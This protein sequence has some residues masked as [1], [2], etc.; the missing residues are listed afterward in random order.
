[1]IRII[2]FHFHA[3]FQVDDFVLNKLHSPLL[4]VTVFKFQHL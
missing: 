4:L 3:I 2:L 1:V